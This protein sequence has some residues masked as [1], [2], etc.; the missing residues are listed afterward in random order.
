MC[1]EVI[2]ETAHIFYKE[3]PI[4]EN[5]IFTANIAEENEVEDVRFKKSKEYAVTGLSFSQDLDSS[6]VSV[7]DTGRQEVINNLI[8]KTIKEKKEPDL[9]FRI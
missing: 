7:T 1:T 2:M 3:I 5:S 4:D 9:D 6:L 8:Q